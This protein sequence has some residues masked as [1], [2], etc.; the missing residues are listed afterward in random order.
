MELL[1]AAEYISLDNPQRGNDLVDS[2]FQYF[3]KILSSFPESG[4]IHT[5]EIR[6]LSHRGYTAF[7]S[8]KKN[9]QRVFVL[10]I[11]DLTKPLQARNIDF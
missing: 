1:E 8:I 7:Y 2:L 10:H 4:M 3:T 9:E 11:V 5:S 6:K